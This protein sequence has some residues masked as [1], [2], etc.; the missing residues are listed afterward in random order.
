M[1]PNS[2]GA[3]KISSNCK[4][5]T[6]SLHLERRSTEK[7]SRGDL[8]T[9][10]GISTITSLMKGQSMVPECYSL[11]LM[12]K[13]ISF[14]V[15][16]PGLKPKIN[17]KDLPFRLTAQLQHIRARN[18]K[19]VQ[20][21][22]VLASRDLLLYEKRFENRFEFARWLRPSLRSSADEMGEEVMNGSLIHIPVMYEESRLVPAGFKPLVS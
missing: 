18:I 5:L 15:D 13:I 22:R 6:F 10:S 9:E 12:A 20:I 17:R 11:F 7:R 8:S 4:A 21:V 19:D 14:N 1:S 3:D 2:Y 16:A